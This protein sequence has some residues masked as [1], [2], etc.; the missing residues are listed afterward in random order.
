MNTNKA[1]AIAK[2][3][4]GVRVWVMFGIFGL[5]FKILTMVEDHEDLL[6]NTQFM[7]IAV[8]ILG[9]S[10]LGAVVAFNFGGTAT[11]S[12]VMEQQSNAVI[13]STPISSDHPQE[14]T[15]KSSAADPVI[16]KE[17]AA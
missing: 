10:G 7:T 3:I 16:T 17:T 11:G 1:D 9:G 6:Q 2:F 8:L 5:A 4:P 12:K 15:V 14:V 13:N